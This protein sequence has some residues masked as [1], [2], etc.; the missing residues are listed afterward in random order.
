MYDI[1]Q[2]WLPEAKNT[3]FAGAS[4][5]QTLYRFPLT[6]MLSGELGAG[7]TTF[8]QGF[9]RAL[10][11]KEPITSPTYAL[12]QRYHARDMEILH[13]DLYR[14]SPKQAEELV[15]SSDNHQGIRCIEW[16][17]RLTSNEGGNIT[18]TLKEEQGAEGRQLR[19]CF[20][21]MALMEE[22]L[23]TKW[24]EEMLL[25]PPIQRHCEGVAT[26]A[27]KLADVLRNR[28][29]IIRPLAL[30]R[31]G[32]LHD[33]MRFVD[34]TP[35]AAHVE[36]EETEEER[37]TW[38]TWKE[39]YPHLR[40]EPAIAAFLRDQGFLGLATI[41]ETHGP[42]TEPTERHTI[43]QQL[44]YYADKRMMVD[45]LVTLEERFDDFKK[46]YR[47]GKK[48]AEGEKWLRDAKDLETRLFPNGTP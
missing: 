26:Y 20:D 19:I 27:A 22:D 45:Q 4:L 18:I 48:S 34:F 10:G 33:L 25:P 32:Q 35:G 8:L 12:E 46:R 15:S 9:L 43:E 6:I 47:G 3:E 13:I 31:A 5:A 16:G 30:K 14:L 29:H 21:D 1:T 42:K 40:H 23:I 44:I 2:I 37:R 28:G 7:K 11:A 24:R 41:V 17:D 38:N 39:R 36:T